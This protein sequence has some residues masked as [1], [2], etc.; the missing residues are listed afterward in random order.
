MNPGIILGKLSKLKPMKI[1]IYGAGTW[2][3]ALAELLVQNGYDV[4]VW[5]YKHTFLNDL[6]KSL[7]HPNLDSHRLSKK[8]KF[9]DK[10]QFQSDV[11]MIVIATPSQSIRDLL[12][13]INFTE[14]NPI[15]VCVSKGLEKESG[16]TMSQVIHDVTNISNDKICALYGPSHAEEVM[17]KIPTAI[18]AASGSLDTAKIVQDSFSNQFFRVYSSDDILGVEFGGSIKNVIAIAAGICKGIGYGDNTIAALITRGTKELSRLG[19]VFGAKRETFFGLSGMGD[20]IVTATSNH[21]RNRKVGEWIGNG[22]TLGQI[23][24]KMKMVAEGV[25]TTLAINKLAEIKNIEM[26]ICKEVFHIL[27]EGK[28]PVIAIGDLMTRELISE[29]LNN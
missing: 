13:K 29:Y 23:A 9:T 6:Q 15:V 19:L 21:S 4:T 20:L 1:K 12:Q 2:G 18:V 5:H 3:I 7:I 14:N 24:K 16:M 25:D 17:K 26:P 22:L 8:V 27:F 28:N 11:N 10:I